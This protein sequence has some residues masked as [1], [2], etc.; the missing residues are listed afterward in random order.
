MN[1]IHCVSSSL[2]NS[3]LFVGEMNLSDVARDKFSSD[4]TF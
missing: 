2:F 1:E 4:D 3:I